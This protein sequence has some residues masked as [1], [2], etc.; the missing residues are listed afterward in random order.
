MT[1]TLAEPHS[2]DRVPAGV[3]MRADPSSSLHPVR[4]RAGP[5]H[6][7]GAPSTGHAA[8]DLPQVSKVA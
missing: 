4:H 1:F 7:L 3:G 6:A 2:G 8:L 5:L